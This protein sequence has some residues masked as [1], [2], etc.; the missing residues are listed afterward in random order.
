MARKQLLKVMADLPPCLIGMEVCATAHHWARELMA[1][2]HEVRL[3]SPACVKRYVKRNKNDAT[4]VEVICEAVTWPT[5]RFVPVKTMDAQ[6]IFM[7][8]RA[9]Y[10]LV[11]QRTVQVSAMRAHLAEYGIVV[12]KGRS[13]VR[14]LMAAVEAEPDNL[15]ALA[16][17]AVLLI[18]RMIE[19]LS[20][21][22]RLIKV[23]LMAW[24]TGQYQSRSSWKRYPALALSRPRH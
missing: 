10:L 8:H 4:D 22:I 21:Q 24:G 6:S 23:E 9:R 2:G 5:M 16:R 17:K 7:L 12:V 13:H 3:M 11:R 19:T 1:L 14:D 18:G 20:E 15:P